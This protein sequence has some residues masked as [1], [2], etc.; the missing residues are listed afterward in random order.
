MDVVSLCPFVASKVVWQAHSGAFALTVMV[1]ATFVLQSGTA[2]VAPEQD[3]IYE[4]DRFYDDDP[5]RSVRYPSDVVPYKP[6]ADVLLVGRAY[7]PKKQPVR[8]LVTRFVVGEVDKSIEV[9]CDRAFRV[10]DGQLLEGKRFTEMPLV[11]ERASGGPESANPVGKRFD[12]GMDVYGTIAIGNLQP[13]GH[14]VSKR[15][16]TFVPTCYGPIAP[17][18][19]GR[20]QRLGRLSRSILQ[21]V[22]NTQKLPPDLDPSFFQSASS[23]QVVSEIRANERI[24]L[25]NLHPEHARL[26]TNLPGFMPRAIADRATGEREEIKLIGDTLL[27]DTDRGVCTVV[28]RGRMGLRH[29][30]ETGRIAIWVDGM[31]MANPDAP[32]RSAV[33]I[34]DPAELVTTMIPLAPKQTEVL[35]F[36]AGASSLAQ[37]SP[38]LP[39]D[40]GENDGTGTMFVSMNKVAAK[41]T[42]FEP[43][44]NAEMGFDRPAPARA[45]SAVATPFVVPA[46]PPPV[47]VASPS[48]NER[49]EWPELAP[50]TPVPPPIEVESVKKEDVAPPA[51][52]GPLARGEV[53]PE[54]VVKQE[55]LKAPVA[56]ASV[57]L[58][59]TVE[60]PKKFDPAD[61]P[62]EKCAALTASIARMKSEKARILDAEE[63]NEANWV[64]V[65]Q[66]WDQAIKDETKKG[67]R[68]LLDRF[69]NAYVEQLEKERGPITVEEYARLSVAGERGT[70]DEELKALRLPRGATVRIERLWH[71][72]CALDLAFAGCTESAMSTARAT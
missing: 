24:V 9:W 43:P 47:F 3:P 57:V 14:F 49:T 18:W 37:S 69:D 41:A 4:Q 39:I 50:Y 7:A 12:G 70:L 20:T 42:P 48:A 13:L 38:G 17:T 40:D 22:W 8:S 67:R 52:I 19:P 55:E 5:R 51:M 59:P 10:I 46:A 45:I 31:A 63:I 56:I 61:F 11:W 71:N 29:P 60:A 53:T 26:V 36:V 27:V 28:W 68:T 21:G 23:D 54:V 72:R 30:Q 58:A 25:E 65:Q 62:L 16:D 32:Q 66:Y 35:P 44:G 2:L 64:R 15:S 34:E 1:K 6:R 33:V